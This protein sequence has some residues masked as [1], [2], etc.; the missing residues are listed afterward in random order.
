MNRPVSPVRGQR[1]SASTELALLTPA[2]VAV[3][4]LM[5]AFGRMARGRADVDSAARDAARAASLARSPDG[6]QVLAEQA[7]AATLTTEGLSCRHFQVVVDLADFRPGGL[8]AADV[9]CA[10]DLADLTL[11]RLP[12]SKML[13][14]RSVSVVDRFRET[15]P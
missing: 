8:V 4:L 6:A 3:L 14:A 11:L 15:A 12:G 1:G 13:T 2:L 9:S 10:V 7:A 5:V